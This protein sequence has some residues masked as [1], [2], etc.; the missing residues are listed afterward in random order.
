MSEL[1]VAKPF[2]DLYSEE[3]QAR[4][5]AVALESWVVALELDIWLAVEGYTRRHKPEG[6]VLNRCS[7]GAHGPYSSQ[8]WIWSDR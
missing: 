1:Q 7:A 6:R 3:Q 2:A 8:P 4:Y 5:L